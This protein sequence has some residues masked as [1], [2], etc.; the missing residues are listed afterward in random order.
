MDNRKWSLGLGSPRFI[1]AQVVPI[2]PEAPGERQELGGRVGRQ[3]KRRSDDARHLASS[4]S[5]S[6][7]IFRRS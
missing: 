5:V 4:A 3:I 1:G 6:M 2:L 7:E